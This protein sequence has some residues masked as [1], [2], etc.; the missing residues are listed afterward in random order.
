MILAKIVEGKKEALRVEEVARIL[1]VS[2][3]KIYRMAANGQIP[4]LKIS[5]SIRFDPHDFAVWLKCQSSINTIPAVLLPSRA[6]L[7]RSNGQ[8]LDHPPRI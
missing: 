5:H 3:K 8:Q 1:N 6:Y 2:I 4:C 7:R